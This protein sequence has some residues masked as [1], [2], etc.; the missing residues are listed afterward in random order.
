MSCMAWW[1][2]PSHYV[3]TPSR[4]E[5]ELDCDNLMNVSS[6]INCISINIQH[7]VNKVVSTSSHSLVS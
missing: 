6:F 1:D 3:V 4:V 7:I 5:V 2:G